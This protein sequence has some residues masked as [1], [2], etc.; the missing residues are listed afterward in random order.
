MI[1]GRTIPPLGL[2]KV[3]QCL[4]HPSVVKPAHTSLLPST[5]LALCIITPQ[6]HVD[7]C[8]TNSPS[9]QQ[10]QLRCQPSHK[11]AVSAQLGH[12]YDSTHATNLRDGSQHHMNTHSMVLP[13]HTQLMRAS[14]PLTMPAVAC[15]NKSGCSVFVPTQHSLAH[16]VQQRATHTARCTAH[17]LVKGRNRAALSLRGLST[18]VC[19]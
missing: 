14:T 2:R 16:L 11:Y 19:S 10:S 1:L 3:T 15:S 6:R 5:V 4:L 12:L 7:S 13:A 9:R 8:T 18:H 17:R